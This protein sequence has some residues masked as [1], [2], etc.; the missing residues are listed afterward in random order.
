MTVVQL[1][2][3]QISKPSA[4]G[5]QKTVMAGEG[6]ECSV[7]K[8]CVHSLG[9]YVTFQ[10][11]EGVRRGNLL[12]GTAEIRNTNNYILNDSSIRVAWSCFISLLFFYF[13]FTLLLVVYIHV[14]GTA[15]KKKKKKWE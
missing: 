13:F 6:L 12:P 7:H 8:K 15:L 11:A 9:V 4:N 14:A 1:R 10:K 2:A 5:G 3:D